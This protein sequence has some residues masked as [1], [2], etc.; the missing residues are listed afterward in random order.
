MLQSSLSCSI[1][2]KLPCL[3]EKTLSSFGF[4]SLCL[5]PATCY[6]GLL[7]PWH[8]GF[9]ERDVSLSVTSEP[10]CAW[11]GVSGTLKQRHKGPG[12]GSLY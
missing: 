12:S 1:R 5:V 11:I 6:S 2:I 9:V 4:V 8:V 10:L 3:P 7:Y